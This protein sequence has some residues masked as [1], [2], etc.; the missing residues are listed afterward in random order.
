M[1]KILLLALFINLLAS[2]GDN[3]DDM[4]YEYQKKS[5]MNL[6]LDPN[7]LDFEVKNVK[8]IKEIKSKDSIDLIKIELAK[9]WK[10]NPSKEL[11]DTLTINHVRN[12]LIKAK[13]N[14]NKISET[15]KKIIKKSIE[16][17]F[18]EYEKEHREKLAKTKSDFLELK[19][20]LKKID[21]I[22]K[23]QNRYIKNP[24]DLISVKYKIKYTMRNPLMN[25]NKQTFEKYFYTNKEQTKIILSRSLT[26]N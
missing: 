10:P 9:Y 25:N 4:L 17:G 11:I 3:V 16:G 14:L 24:E 15:H 7:D 21:E 5:T 19:T 20:Y 18:P 8:K 2:C 6:N 22:E 12:E 13:N 1:K 26:N 23:R